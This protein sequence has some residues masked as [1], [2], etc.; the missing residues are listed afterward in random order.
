MTLRPPVQRSS[1]KIYAGKV[2]K[3]APKLSLILYNKSV[4]LFPFEKSKSMNALLLL[5]GHVPS[6]LKPLFFAFFFLKKKGQRN[7]I[8]DHPFALY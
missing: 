6:P 5:G 1:V 7:K 3:K 8:Y 4:N 2:T